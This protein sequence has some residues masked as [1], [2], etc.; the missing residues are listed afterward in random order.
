[1]KNVIVNTTINPPTEAIRKFEALKDWDLVVIG[2][3]ETPKDY[4]LG[5]RLPGT[6][7]DG[8]IIW[9]PSFWPP[10][11]SSLPLRLKERD[12]RCGLHRCSH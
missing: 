6:L 12:H 9:P 8:S 11:P 5:R 7:M 10:R 3:L 4:R 1:M 2:D